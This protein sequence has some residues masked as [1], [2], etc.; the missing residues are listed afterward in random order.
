M[1]IKGCQ[2]MANGWNNLEI[3]HIVNTITLL[4]LDGLRLV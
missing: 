4:R 1:K 3:G 2:Q